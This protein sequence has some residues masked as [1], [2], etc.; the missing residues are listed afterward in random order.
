VQKH[1]QFLLAVLVL[2]VVVVASSNA[3][4]II[5]AGFETGSLSPWFQDQTLCFDKCENWNVTSLDSHSGTF[6]A[7]EVGDN[8]LRQNFDPI[9]T[10]MIT[11]VSFWVK[12]PDGVAPTGVDFFY[13]D[14]TSSSFAVFTHDANW[15]FFDV[16]SQLHAGKTLNGID[17]FGFSGGPP[18][19]SE[20]TFIDD[21]S[22]V[23]PGSVPE[24]SGL[25]LIAT[26]ML[27]FIAV[28]RTNRPKNR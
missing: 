7:T 21:V 24:P 16:T 19:T 17:L 27:T 3:D 5:N 13:S 20:R 2:V 22:I 10:A 12:H 18:G 15:D 25:G 6:S 9:L 26:G 4:T 28:N 14:G 8:S 1:F 11:D 23:A